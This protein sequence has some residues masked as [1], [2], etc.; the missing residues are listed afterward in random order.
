MKWPNPLIA[1]GKREFD[2]VK[3]IC[4]ISECEPREDFG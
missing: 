4:M 2:L 1:K 3:K